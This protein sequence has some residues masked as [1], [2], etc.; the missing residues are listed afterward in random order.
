VP[1]NRA[2]VNG[3]DK[4]VEVLVQAGA[5]VN[6]AYKVQHVSHFASPRCTATVDDV[7]GTANKQALTL[8]R[9]AL[10]IAEWLDAPSLR[11]NQWPRQGC[12]GAGA[13]RCRR[14]RC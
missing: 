12:G 2:A 3:H 14:D 5:D 7:Q 1:L 6:A 11:C 13:S 10:V 9:L 8:C 4:V